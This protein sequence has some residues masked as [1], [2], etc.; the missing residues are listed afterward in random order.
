MMI[1][2]TKKNLMSSMMDVREMGDSP[3][4]F[5]TK[6]D[7]DEVDKS[8]NRITG[9]LKYTTAITSNLESN[10]RLLD[11]VNFYFKNDNT[12]QTLSPKPFELVILPHTFSRLTGMPITE[13][14]KIRDSLFNNI[15]FYRYL[16]IDTFNLVMNGK[17]VVDICTLE[18]YVLKCFSMYE[19]SGS[20]SQFDDQ[21]HVPMKFSYDDV[22]GMNSDDF[23]LRWLSTSN[24]K[25]DFRIANRV[26]YGLYQ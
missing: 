16:V 2:S 15:P 22:S 26:M 3:S 12:Y 10:T 18:S 23:F 13:M 9:E 21:L 24:G 20:V 11:L 4:T 17:R 14:S 5:I 25:E 1:A 6:K 19:E 8:L 7:K